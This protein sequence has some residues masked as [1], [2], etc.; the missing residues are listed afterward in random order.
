MRRIKNITYKILSFI[1]IFGFIASNLTGLAYANEADVEEQAETPN[2]Q[3]E[4]FVT[5]YGSDIEGDGT[6]EKPY[7]TVTKARDKVREINSN[8]TG[9][10]VVHIG[11]GDYYLN[12]TIKFGVN[13]SGTNGYNIIYRSSDGLGTAR[14]IGGVKLPNSWILA[15]NTDVNGFNLDPSMVGKVYKLQLDKGKYQF[16]TLYVN[17]RRVVMARTKNYEFNERFETARDGYMYSAGGGS[18]DL[19]Y[20]DGDLSS[21]DITGMVAAQ[22]R[23]EK[24]IAQVRVW[25]GGYWNWFTSTLPV[26]T[27]NSS[28]R[29]L[30]FPQIP[31]QPA[32]NRPKYNVESGARYYLQGNLAFLDVEGEYHYNKATGILYY[33]PKASDGAI[34]NQEII[35]PTMQ[36]IIVLKGEEKSN[37]AA[38]PDPNKQVHN[39]TF[40]GLS[41]ECTEY[42]NSFSSAWNSFDAKGGIGKFPKEA[43]LPEVTNPSYCEQTDRPEFQ[44]GAMTLTYTN[45]ITIDSV[46][47]N[48]TG[49]FGIA[50]FR[51]NNNNTV[52]NSEIAYAGY[53]GITMDGGY[54]GVGK[55][56]HNITVTNSIIHDVGELIGHASG[57][58]V[59][60]THD[61]YFTNLEIYNSPRRGIFMNG[62]WWMRHTS[63]NIKCEAGCVLDRFNRYTDAYSY[64]NKFEYLYLH[65]LQQDGGDDGAIFFCTLYNNNGQGYRD[66]YM[67]QVYIDMVG[68][69]PTMNDFK[70]N[71]VNLDMGC[72]GVHLSNMKVVNPHHYNYRY[73]YGGSYNDVLYIDNINAR[74]YQNESFDESKMEYDKIGVT[75]DYPYETIHK[76]PKSYEDVYYREEFDNGLIDWWKLAGK[77]ETSSIY[78]SDNDDFTGNSFL[79]DAFYNKSTE[80]CK[81]GKPFGRELNKVVEIDY[82]DHVNDSM[83]NGYCGREFQYKLNSFARVDNGTNQIAI[84]VNSNINE[85]YYSYL[86]GSTNTVTNIKREYGWHTFKWDYTSGTDVK[87]Y[88]DGNLIATA[89]A[90]NFSYIEMGD[91]GMGGFNAF[92]NVVI[93]GGNAAEPP[94]QLPLIKKLPGKIEAEKADKLPGTIQINSITGGGKAI[95]Y[96]SKGD[97]YEYEL[98]V[99]EDCELPLTVRHAGINT[100][101][102]FKLT[103]GNQ[104]IFVDLP[105]TGGWTVYKEM[106]TS[107]KLKLTKGI[108]T[109]KVEVVDNYFNFDW[110]ALN[111]PKPFDKPIDVTGIDAVYGK[112]IKVQNGEVFNFNGG[113][114]IRY[115]NIDFGT[116][117]KDLKFKI[118]LAVHPNWAGK[119]V[120]VM[121]DDVKNGK[122]LGTVTVKAN[123]VGGDWGVYYLHEITLNTKLSGVHT[124]YLLGEGGEGIG[125]VKEIVFEDITP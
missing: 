75:A 46:K 12:D 28:S 102:S 99:T 53:G 88:I 63:H 49:L 115:D 86:V 36:E 15:D 59:M 84:G 43:K 78:Y 22:A 105:Q 101:G 10:I 68:A 71:G 9:N 110:F 21:K 121:L 72:S 93:Y 125:G 48:N 40:Y 25:D 16:N 11:A 34:D 103:V 3:A 4:I 117:Q 85:K 120:H 2:V 20:K 47:I 65:D 5:V 33:Y 70:A 77:P 69:T 32:T 55:Y 7:A 76:S 45:N 94:I 73:D 97:V 24:E 106:T 8:M 52:K 41:L 62:A 79:A 38:V 122:N 100:G 30:T 50:L 91:Y 108:Y 64:N 13:D 23:G 37:L 57:I 123:P 82:F 87:M 58:T 119:K 107:E 18:F 35:V 113:D 17:G 66:N 44:K 61:S 42:T 89:P 114:W 111:L 56:S 118:N 83:E 39:I 67:N 26:N 96:I 116:T 124:I 95:E 112:Y 90:Y 1:L 6:R 92:D 81:I 27:I 109:A 74:Y 31:D 51:D 54:P 98:E 104:S 29:R 14:L 60:Q 19:Y 80:G